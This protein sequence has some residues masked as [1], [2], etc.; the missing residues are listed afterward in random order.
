MTEPRPRLTNTIGSVQQTSVVSDDARPTAVRNLGRIVPPQFVKTHHDT[1]GGK[2]DQQRNRMQMRRVV[3]SLECG[4]WMHRHG[5]DA[6]RPGWCREDGERDSDAAVIRRRR[7]SGC[8]ADATA[9]ALAAIV[10]RAEPGALV[11]RLRAAR[12]SAHRELQRHRIARC[13]HEGDERDED[14][15][16]MHGLLAL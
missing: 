10:G 8:G 12:H 13:G 7:C 1:D 15:S 16:Q 6:C 9:H 2:S 5:G 11:V 3:R 14:L 4:R